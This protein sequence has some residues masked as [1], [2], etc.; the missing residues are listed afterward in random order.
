MRIDVESAQ[1]TCVMLVLMVA[2]LVL[3][4]VAVLVKTPAE[5]HARAVSFVVAV[6]LLA[7]FAIALPSIV[8]GGHDDDDDDDQ[9]APV[10]LASAAGKPA[11]RQPPPSARRLPLGWALILLAASGLLIGQESNWLTDPMSA[12]LA[13]LHINDGFAGL[14][15]VGTIANLSQV[16]P[17]IQL[18]LRGDADTAAQINLQ[19]S[20]QDALMT[21]PLLMLVSPLIG[22]GSFTLVFSPLMVVALV[23][24][25]LL[26]VFVIFDGEVNYLEGV[27]LIGLYIVLGSLFWWS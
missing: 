5:H 16:G 10:G 9:L 7:V 4:A 19:G 26:V 20:L 21:A 25:S 24:A 23:V 17:A 3:P 6:V 11:A 1:N 2:T 15:I 14:F 18:A 22:A 8:R 13:R 12:A 27:M